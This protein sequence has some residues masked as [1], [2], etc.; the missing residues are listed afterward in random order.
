MNR[1]L[2]LVLLSFLL[3][4]IAHSS[5]GN[6]HVGIS[7]NEIT[8]RVEEQI[9]LG[10][11]GSKER[12]NLSFR[13][14]KY[15]FIRF[16]RVAQGSLDP[17]RVKT[18]YLQNDQSKLLFISLDVI[19]VTKDMRNDLIARL[20]PLGIKAEEVI[21]SG[22]H[23]HAG[24]GA[25]SKNFFW[26][27]FAMD[28]FQKKYYNR[29]LDQ[30]TTAVTESI[31]KIQPAE[32]W[33][34]SFPTQELVRNRRGADRPLDPTANF[35]MARGLDGEWLGGIVNYAV[36]GTS[37]GAGNL[38]FSADTPGAIER[39]I[40]KLLE[41]ENGSVRLSNSPKMLFINGAEG[42]VSPNHNPHTRMGEEFAEQTL[43]HW[44]SLK[45]LD[46][47]WKVIQKQITLNKPKI[48]LK[49]CVDKKWMPK[50][51]K[52]GLRKFV[53]SNTLINQVRFGSL[54][55]LTWPGEPTTELGINLRA[56]ATL[57]GATDAWVF[58]LTNDHLGYFTTPEEFKIGGYEACVNF[59]GET[60]G[61]LILKEHKNLS[62]TK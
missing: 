27:V 16:F 62:I 34:L 24:P 2:V 28:R 26:Q 4:T 49:K 22:T 1:L 50:G 21:I 23:T 55:F 53:S 29:F 52:I 37:L 48:Q 11:Y 12:R 3:S 7:A 43:Q 5:E 18:M 51:F 20:K 40:E 9:P 46:P 56:Q 38:F 60:G 6:L 35:L 41:T 32:L 58:G 42:D 57:D 54:W 61:D 19:G 13:L 44:H 45:P 33:T 25:L 10:G 47:Q 39:N 59:F 8:P 14:F 17:I 30:V 36:H 31:A 15:P